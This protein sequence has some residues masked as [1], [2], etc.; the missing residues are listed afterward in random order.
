MSTVIG[1]LSVSNRLL[2]LVS[3]FSF[4]GFLFYVIG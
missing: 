1:V 2:I 4:A 3:P